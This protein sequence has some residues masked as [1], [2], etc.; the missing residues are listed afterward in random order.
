MI[1]FIFGEDDFRGKEKTKQL[2]DKFLRD[3]DPSGN[4]VIPISGEDTSIKEI[5]EKC[6]TSSL[7]SSK[8]MVIIENLFTNSSIL[9]EAADY[10]QK[11][12][13]KNSDN[14]IVFWEPRVKTK[15]KKGQKNPLFIDNWGRE[16]PLTKKAQKLFDLLNGQQYVQEFSLLPHAEVVKWLQERIKQRNG[17]ISNKAAQLLAGMTG[18]ELWQLS[19]EIE[20]LIHYKRGQTSEQQVEIESEDI[21]EVT[22]GLFHQDIFALTDAVG[23]KNAATAVRLLEEQMTSGVSEHFLLNMIIRQVKILLQVRQSLDAG[24]SSGK[25]AGQLKLH[26]FVVQKAINQVRKFELERLKKALNKLIEIDSDLKSGRGE[27]KSMLDLF[28]FKL[29]S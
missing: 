24:M 25:I 9:E 15:N 18:G 1:I 3:V 20:K 21:K 7:F 16:K 12:A 23:S 10:F 22:S 5:N 27:I 28:I 14:V 6:S 13:D 19:L 11:E 26:P 2:K 4:S 29:S 17:N 8:R